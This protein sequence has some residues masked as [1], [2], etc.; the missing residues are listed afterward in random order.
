MISA[1]VIACSLAL[2]AVHEVPPTA[3]S[4]VELQVQALVADL[5]DEAFHVRRSAR[6]GLESLGPA[7]L[8]HLVEA[9]TGVQNFEAQEAL[10]VAIER[11]AVAAEAGATRLTLRF[12]DADP[13]DVLARITE[14]AETEIRLEPADLFEDLNF[15]PVTNQWD[16]APAWQVLRDLCETW[17]LYL[18]ADRSGWVMSSRP[19]YAQGVG[20][21]TVVDGFL[22]ELDSIRRDQVVQF[23]SRG[24]ARKNEFTVTFQCYPEPKLRPASR[25]A[26]ATVAHAVDDRGNDLADA[27]K[28]R[29]ADAPGQG[30][31][32]CVQLDHPSRDALGRT[33]TEMRGSIALDVLAGWERFEPDVQTGGEQ[34]VETAA[35]PLKLTVEPAEVQRSGGLAI[36]VHARQ[37]STGYA[38]AFAAADL[39]DDVRLVDATGRVF[40][41]RV[42]QRH[43]IKRNGHAETRATLLTS[44]SVE[45][46]AR[47]QWNV[48]SRREGITIPY[49][50]DN[51][52]IP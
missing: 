1:A 33:I 31:V 40:K 10:D 49:A 5:S 44:G 45:M 23:A 11:L 29:V 4:S 47:I 36:D 9:R 34:T 46:P 6:T 19:H 15:A 32:V 35:G 14:A 39:L 41:L 52:P 30:F 18:R 7:A 8:P 17:G 38:E 28:V 50:F 25:G 51:L 48:P 21:S 3:L 24:T 26:A 13:A 27:A 42:E 12:N 37:P 20:R 43:Q 2:G 16:A 22:L